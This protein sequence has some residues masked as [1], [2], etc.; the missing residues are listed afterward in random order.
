[1]VG[2]WVK[3]VEEHGA[4]IPVK[5]VMLG[6]PACLSPK[7]TGDEPLSFGETFF[8]SP[9]LCKVSHPQPLVEAGLAMRELSDRCLHMD[10]NLSHGLHGS[11]CLSCVDGLVFL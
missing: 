1:M 8:C 6:V 7:Q 11:R 3:Q 10:S 9:A 2:G 4:L 5:S